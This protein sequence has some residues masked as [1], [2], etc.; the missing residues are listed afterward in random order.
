MNLFANRP[1]GTKILSGFI[2]LLFILVAVVGLAYAN[3]HTVAALFDVFGQRVAVVGDANLIDRSLAK[4]RQHVREYALVG[5]PQEA[6]AAHAT[7][8]T[9]RN[10]IDAALA[11]IRTPDRHQH[12][13]DIAQR[14]AA[15]G[16]GA[17]KMM[18]LR[19][20][21]D[22][23]MRETLDPTGLQVTRAF[24]AVGNALQQPGTDAAARLAETGGQAFMEI[25]LQVNKSVGRREDTAA[26]QQSQSA[27]D[28][29]GT[30]LNRLEEATVG[31]PLR[32]AVD[33]LRRRVQTY[34]AAA[35][36]VGEISAALDQQLNG[37]LKRTGDEITRAS[38]AIVASAQAEQ[39]EVE[40]SVKATISGTQTAL[41]A[42]GGVG[43]A[44]GL[45]LAWL[46]G[47]S[48]VQPVVRMTAVMRRIADGELDATI[49]AIE[50]S[51]E[52]GLMAHAVQVF[53]DNAARM[54]TMEQEKAAEAESRQEA[55]K[56]EMAALASNFEAR[57]GGMAGQLAAEAAHLRT[58][59]ET[60]AETATSA[61]AQAST[62][63][64]AAGDASAGV[65]TVAA[66]AEE[67]SSSITEISRQVA[68]SAR[69]TEK[70]VSDARQTDATVR[71]L[72]EGAR[73]I[74][75]VV[76][77]I[78]DIAGQTN[79]LALNAT[80]EAARA[81]DA[82]KGFAVVASE[83]KSLA[84]Q[85]A[86][87]TEEIGSHIGQ[88]QTATQQAVTAIHGITT[89]IEE[90]STIATAIAAAVEEQGS[91][92][93]EIARNVQQTAA[94][95]LQVTT[96]IAD[97]SHAADSTG[98]TAGEVLNAAAQLAGQADELSHEMNRF[99]V[100]VRAA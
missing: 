73:K 71:A 41:L 68:Q 54:R 83:V 72:A 94:S 22:K 96:T 97:V 31:T 86:K 60:M 91:A 29:L 23:L 47:R 38:A 12:M 89:V 77:L 76:G 11:Q 8:G 43:V 93:N 4:L 32:N 9:V 88:I 62:V 33:D 49:P 56:R 63:A 5:R 48:V 98:A 25:R 69:I 53:R 85:T 61:R 92:T 44:V 90:V 75:D 42:S 13:Q 20:E 52:V 64:V 70:A 35:T 39:Q 36:R 17:E 80:I 16:E 28:L 40:A 51:N 45:L 7:I 87:A 46:I 2:G 99:V 59:A 14:F 27:Q 100:T 81:G 95:T 50:Q 57:I 21:Q 82:G 18:A 6:D 26:A 78:T 24:I 34:Q 37:D 10:A 74:G 1:I 15:Y 84:Q 55:R 66:A 30:T 19:A 58:T 65:Q 79:L 67:L 3:F